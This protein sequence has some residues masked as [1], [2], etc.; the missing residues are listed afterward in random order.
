MDQMGTYTYNVAQVRSNYLKPLCINEYSIKDTLEFP[1]LLKDLLP[2]KDDEEYVSY[3]VKS[4]FTNIPQKE[5]IDYIL[6]QIY[7]HNK[8][9]MIC[10]KLIFRR[11]LEKMTTKNLFKLHSK[12]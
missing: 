11:L 10:S 2:L 4:L 8:L 5:T 1:Q 7:V 3:D 9:P 12:K 6:E